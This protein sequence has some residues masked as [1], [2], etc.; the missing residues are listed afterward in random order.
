MPGE[1]LVMFL[2]TDL[3][4]LSRGRGSPVGDLDDRLRTGVG[5]VPADQALTAFGPIADPN[6]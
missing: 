1:E 4:G 2:H 3:S 5:W 6:P